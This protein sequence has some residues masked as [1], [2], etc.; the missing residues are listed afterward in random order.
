MALKLLNG[1]NLNMLRSN[2]LSTQYIKCTRN[3]PQKKI[4]LA[5]S[6]GCQVLHGHKH[7]ALPCCKQQIESNGLTIQDH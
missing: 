1:F 2:T 3:G 6:D 4:R 5:E 7:S